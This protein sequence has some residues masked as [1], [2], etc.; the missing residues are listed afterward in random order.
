MIGKN[1]QISRIVDSFLQKGIKL[2]HQRK[3]IAQVITDA[4]DHPDAN[5]VFMRANKIDNRISLATVY[6][7]IKLF[8]ENKVL[9]RIDLVEKRLDMKN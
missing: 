2:T 6:R 5:E 9:N 1:K 3:V 4:S 8:E 7:T